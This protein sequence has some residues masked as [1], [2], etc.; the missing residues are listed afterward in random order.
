MEFEEVNS[1]GNGTTS[2]D[3]WPRWL[4]TMQK[5]LA[6]PDRGAT[7]LQGLFVGSNYVDTAQYRPSAN[8]KMNSLFG[9]ALDTSFNSVSREKMIMDI[10]RY[11]TPIDSTTPAAGAAPYPTTLTV[12][13]IDPAVIAVDWSVDGDVRL[14]NGG[15]TFDVASQALPAGSH[16]IVA[17]AYDNAS[18][19]LVLQVPGSTWGRM[20]WARSVQTVT[21]TVTVP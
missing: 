13:V 8:S 7:G 10:W 6:V 1:T 15:T 5:G 16:T 21:W 17:K 11:V 19:D 3:K 2:T 20:N 18:R 12:N 4:G 9:N 14:T